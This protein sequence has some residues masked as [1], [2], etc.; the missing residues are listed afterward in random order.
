MLRHL[1]LIVA[2]AFATAATAASTQPATRKPGYTDPFGYFTTDA[3]FEVWH[4]LRTRLAADFDAICGD[5]FCEGDFGNITP[6]RFECSVQRHTGR[7]GACVWSFA[8]SAEDIDPVTGLVE[9]RQ[10]SWQCPIPVVPGTA[11]DA[12]LAALAGDAPLRTPLP[13]TGATV[14]D[15]LG[16]CL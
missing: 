6:M 2:A 9:V 14:W 12:L 15:G 10:P 13:G 4:S 1:P 3:Q 16:H 5:T 7:I 11:I 8:A